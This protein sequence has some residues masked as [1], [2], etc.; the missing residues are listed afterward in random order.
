[1]SLMG[2]LFTSASVLFM[3]L[4][5]GTLT[6]WVRAATDSVGAAEQPWIQLDAGAAKLT[7]P[8]ARAGDLFVVKAELNGH[9]AG[10]FIV[11]TGAPH[12]VVGEDVVER[13]ALVP[14]PAGADG[15]TRVVPVD[16][17][18]IG[19]LL[20]RP[21]Y[22]Q[23]I[24]LRHVRVD[25]GAPIGGIVGNDLWGQLPFA[26][27][28]R[29]ATLTFF[30]RDHFQPPPSPAVAFPLRVAWKLPLV[31]GKIDG[32]D[33][34]FMIDSGSFGTLQ[35]FQKFIDVQPDLLEQKPQWSGWGVGVDG[36]E[37]YT[38]TRLRPP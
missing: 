33:G 27:D 31:P 21:R 1:M 38:N 15:S 7:V 13:L 32:R 11:D 30:D 16:Q 12:T 18:K 3:S 19:N 22:L 35:L 29:A 14:V 34:W 25:L 6:S 20:T 2:R 28:Y 10:W 9:D 23:S 4:C 26:I 17:L 24:D 37:G 8:L 36:L 5:V